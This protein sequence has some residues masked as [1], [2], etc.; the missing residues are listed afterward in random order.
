MDIKKY[1]VHMLKTRP[2]SLITIFI[3]ATLCT[4]ID[5]YNPKFSGYDSLL[6]VEGMITNERAQYEIKL[7]RSMQ[8]ADSIPAKVSD[9]II[10]ITDEGGNQ[11]TLKNFG[12][13]SYK[14]DSTFFVGKIGKT[15]ILHITTGD[16]KEY[17]SEPCVMLP[18]PE[19]DSIYF[20]KDE[21]YTGNQSEVHNGIRIY[22]N[23]KS[24]DINNRYYRW[25]YEETWKFR[26]PDPQ[27]YN[28]INDSVIVRKSDV[29]EFCWK[30]RKS[31]DIVIQSFLPWQTNI[32]KK[33]PLFFIASDKSD[34]LSIQYS[35][36][37]K[38]YSISKKESEFWD[39]MIKVNNSGGD[40]FGSQPF[41]VISNIYNINNPHERIL[42]YFQVSA[43][44]Q[45]RK[46]I[47]FTELKALELP[48]FHYECSRSETEPADYCRGSNFCKPPTWNE[49][50]RMWKDGNFA[51]V[52]PLFDPITGKLRKLVFTSAS[53]SDCELIG[54]LTKPDF[55]VDLN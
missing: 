4:C 40:I 28:Y 55:W 3:I 24:G 36:L 13:G 2:K 50:Y 9:A 27:K 41:P 18:V 8:A 37:V 6:V 12:G 39:N 45:K 11:T 51:F 16:G 42:G 5:P 46:N 20:E 48:Q 14:T 54:T 43:V 49:L 44:K 34:R 21:E 29:K 25:G 7:S 32:V 17:K 52:E 19:I 26:L 31:S 1:N 30:Q 23:S 35:V 15:Y 53:C 47:T 10:F 38:Q 22:L 33:Q